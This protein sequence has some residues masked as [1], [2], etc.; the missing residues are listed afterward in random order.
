MILLLSGFSGAAAAAGYAI[1]SFPA[2]REARQTLSKSDAEWVQNATVMEI[3][4]IFFGMTY[5]CGGLLPCS[6]GPQAWRRR[7]TGT[8]AGT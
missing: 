6:S 5:F 7:S 3:C 1:L 2:S 8:A 4:V